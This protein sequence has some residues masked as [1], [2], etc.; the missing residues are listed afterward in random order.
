M[1]N[2]KLKNQVKN[3][4]SISSWIRDSPRQPREVLRHL[5][6][7]EENLRDW[8]AYTAEISQDEFLTERAS[9]HNSRQRSITDAGILGND[10]LIALR[11]DAAVAFRHHRVDKRRIHA[12]NAMIAPSRVRRRIG[13]GG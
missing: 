13:G 4:R 12:L 3:F 1:D 2:T 8:E 9:R 7:M 10:F 6:D 5:R 11:V